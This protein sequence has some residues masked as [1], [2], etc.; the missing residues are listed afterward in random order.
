MTTEA[1]IAALTDELAETREAAAVLV[2]Q[3]A[4]AVATTPEQRE[5]MALA[6]EAIADG[7]MRSRVTAGLCRLVAERLRAG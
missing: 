6:Y 3:L 4:K 2:S 7:K 5:K 1:K